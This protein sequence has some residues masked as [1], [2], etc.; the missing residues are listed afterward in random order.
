[1]SL[2]F[3]IRF[4][5]GIA[6]GNVTPYNDCVRAMCAILL[7]L[8]KSFFHLFFFAPALSNIFQQEHYVSLSFSF[9]SSIVVTITTITHQFYIS[10]QQLVLLSHHLKRDKHYNIDVIRKFFS[11]YH[12]SSKSHRKSQPPNF[13]YFIRAR[14]YCVDVG[15]HHGLIV[16]VAA[17]SRM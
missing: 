8:T 17:N 6:V 15:C 14:F 4:Y 16:V 12:P 13:P 3:H 9:P 11:S 2:I 1:M 10:L 7:R 5:I